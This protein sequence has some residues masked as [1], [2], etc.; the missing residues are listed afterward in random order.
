M[1]NVKHKGFSLIEVLAAIAIFA[2]ASSSIVLAIDFSA[3]VYREENIKFSTYSA[4]NDLVQQLKAKEVSNETSDDFK[5]NRKL[6][7]LEDVYEIDGDKSIE[8]KNYIIYF[9]Y[10]ELKDTLKD[11]SSFINVADSVNSNFSDVIKYD[12]KK[13]SGKRYA[14]Y[15]TIT[16]DVNQKVNKGNVDVGWFYN[17]YNTGVTVWDMNAGAGSMAKASTSVSR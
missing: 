13:A 17:V 3:K 8:T 6:I 14:A 11:A 10:E 16:K 15:I 7:N 1:I 4:A 9:N 2:V 5:N 12:E